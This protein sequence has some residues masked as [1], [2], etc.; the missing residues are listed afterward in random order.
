MTGISEKEVFEAI[1][2]CLPSLKKIQNRREAFE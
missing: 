1:L 2:R